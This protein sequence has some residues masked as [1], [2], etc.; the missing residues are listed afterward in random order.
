MINVMEHA[1]VLELIGGGLAH[2]IDLG[3]TAGRGMILVAS[4][5]WRA[6]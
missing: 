1:L 4:A 6:R 3:E 2:I 5:A